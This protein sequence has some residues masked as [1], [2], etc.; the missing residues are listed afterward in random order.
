MVP[1]VLTVT[2]L[3][4]TR[5]SSANEQICVGTRQRLEIFN[6]HVILFDEAEIGMLLAGLK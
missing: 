3:G 1:R 2:A 5:Q 4:I 6:R